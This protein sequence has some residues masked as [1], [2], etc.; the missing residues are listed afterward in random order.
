MIRSASPSDEAAAIATVV[1]AFA[2]DPVARWSWPDPGAYLAHFPAF[3]KAFGGR[4][5]AEGAAHTVDDYAGAALWLPPGVGPDEEAMDALL[6]RTT[7]AQLQGDIAALL[8]QMGRYHPSE[9]HWYLP[10]IGV[11]PARQGQGHGSALMRH[12]LAAC[13]RDKRLAYLESTNPRNVPLYQRLGFEAL[14][15]IQAGSSPP[16]FPMLRKPYS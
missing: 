10:L 2:A 3:V 15:T 4:A 6:E 1:L 11:D 8:E 12:A 14:G 5:F 16:L 9:P 7:P 13:D